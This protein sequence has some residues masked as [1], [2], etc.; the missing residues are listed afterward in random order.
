MA[1]LTTKQMTEILTMPPSP[2]RTGKAQA[3]LRHHLKNPGNPGR[4]IGAQAD[5][6]RALLE[7]E[8][9]LTGTKYRHPGFEPVHY[10]DSDTL[11]PTDIAWLQ[12]LPTDPAQ[13][14][15]EDARHI[16]ALVHAVKRTSSDGRLVHAIWDPLKAFHDRRLAETTLK[17]AQRPVS[18]SDPSPAPALAEAILAATPDLRPEE[19]MAR[20]KEIIRN[21]QTELDTH[22]QQAIDTARQT[23]TE[24]DAQ[25]AERAAT[26]RELA[27]R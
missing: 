4:P 15:W 18:V 14:S 10:V 16:V 26:T 20:A 21:T 3:F 5:Y 7:Q 23:I 25:L 8:T 19:A 22:R 2:M 17:N 6:L 27:V 9:S 24:L 13:V 12:R 11:A 1:V